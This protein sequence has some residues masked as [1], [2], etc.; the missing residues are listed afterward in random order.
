MLSKKQIKQIALEYGR[1]KGA[2]E[3]G[4]ELGVPG[5][6]VTKIAYYL[7]KRG[8]DIPFLNTRPIYDLVARELRREHPELFKKHSQKK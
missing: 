2:A 7:R 8:V 5:K 1:K 4:K 6:R 3:L